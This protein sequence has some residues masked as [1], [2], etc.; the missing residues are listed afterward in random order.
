MDYP[1][2]VTFV[3]NLLGLEIPEGNI[4]MM[5]ND[6]FR[7][8]YFRIIYS[9]YSYHNCDQRHPYKERHPADQEGPHEKPQ[10][11]SSSCLPH[12]SVSGVPMVSTASPTGTDNHHRAA[13]TSR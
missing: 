12:I 3:K 6:T 2:N 5:I 8:E 9:S 10:T 1:L 4:I 13:G 7:K 11:K